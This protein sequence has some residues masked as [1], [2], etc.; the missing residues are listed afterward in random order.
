MSKT[1][2][3]RLRDADFMAFSKSLEELCVE[4]AD[5]WAIDAARLQTFRTLLANGLATYLASIDPATRN[6]LSTT[7]KRAAFKELKQFLSLFIDFL[8]GNPA[9]PNEALNILGLRA[10]IRHSYQPLPPPDEAP[11]ISVKHLHNMLIVTVFKAK[12]GNQKE[13][14]RPA[15]AYGIRLHWRFEDETAWRVEL[16]TRCTYTLQFNEGDENKRVIMMAAWLSPRL[17]NGP[18]SNETRALII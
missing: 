17:Q 9:V 12:F 4:H 16:S 14:I 6:H 11:D 8:E 2:S 3:L 1:S 7:L 15:G 13:V 10:R 18:W 5:E